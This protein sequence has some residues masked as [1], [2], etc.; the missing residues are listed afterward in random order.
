M[1]LKEG[2]DYQ[3]QEGNRDGPALLQVSALPV[4][5]RHHD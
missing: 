4:P 5:T 1:A 2:F 3:L